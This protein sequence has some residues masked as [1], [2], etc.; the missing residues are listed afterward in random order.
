MIFYLWRI[1]FLTDN[2]L[3][4]LSNQYSLNY[5]DLRDE[6]R[7]YKTKLSNTHPH[8]N[9]TD[10]KSLILNNHLNVALPVMNELFKILWTIPTNTCECERS[11]STLRRI[12]TYL[13]NTIGQVRLSA[14]ALLNTENEY[15]IDYDE[16]VK[17]VCF[18][19]RQKKDGILVV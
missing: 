5:D 17:R 10:I 14:L 19:Q 7:L 1:L 15:F 6:Q 13:R 8:K 9:L 16:I 11:F 3:K 2:E 4:Q 18:E 12:K